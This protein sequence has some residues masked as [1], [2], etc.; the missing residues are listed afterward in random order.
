GS[1]RVELGHPGPKG[2]P[3]VFGDQIEHSVQARVILGVEV[4]AEST[5]QENGIGELEPAL[6]HVA[7]ELADDGL[8]AQ[9]SFTGPRAVLHTS[10]STPQLTYQGAG[11]FIDGPLR[12]VHGGV[13][14]VG[15]KSRTGGPART[16]GSIRR[17]CATITFRAVGRGRA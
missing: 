15:L 12:N 9:H 2:P 3:R 14:D 13:S 1:G 11:G 4:N 16:S 17:G 7:D 6:F 5:R 8:A 10:G